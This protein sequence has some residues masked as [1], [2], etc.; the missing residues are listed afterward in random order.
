MNN[1]EASRWPLA[2]RPIVSGRARTVVFVSG[3]LSSLLYAAMLLCV[4]LAW[5]EYSSASQ[6]VSELS[7]IGAPTRHLWVSLAFVWTV[8]YA[9][10]GWAVW[11]CAGRNR[12]LRVAGGAIVIAALIGLFWPPM[13][14]REVLAVGEATLTDTLHL[15]WTIVNGTLTLI[16]MG[17]GAAA[18]GKGFRLYSALTMLVVI[19]CGTWTG[20]YAS[21]IRAN[22][23]TPAAGVWERIDIGAWLVWVVVLAVV[24]VRRRPIIS[25]E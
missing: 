15:V 21:G 13:H 4:P 8:L 3:L 16:A 10:F 14:Q 24:L 11:K 7:A 18:L 2:A 22:L 17:F 9:V 1:V 19:A 20:T 5:K 23:P 25:V 6:T 12:K